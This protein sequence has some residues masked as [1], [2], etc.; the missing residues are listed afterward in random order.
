MT[1]VSNSSPLIILAKLNCFELLEKLYSTLCITPEVYS[2]VVVTGT[3][4]PGSAQVMK[5][6]WIDVKAIHNQDDLLAAQK[7]TALGIGELSA[8][9]LAKEITAD[10]V[11]LDDYHAREFARAE[12]L[13][14][15]GTVG[16]LETLHRRGYVSDLRA[17]FQALLANNAY[18]DRR[19]LNRRLQ[20]LGL[21]PL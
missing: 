21:Q 4:R 18:I 7:K 15:R 13:Q 20:S 8:I 10:V 6:G 5:A 1:V 11:L 16:I 12:Q 19:L 3:G 9:V 14:V 17:L 2:E